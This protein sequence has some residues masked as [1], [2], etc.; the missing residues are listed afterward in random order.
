MSSFTQ[1]QRIMVVLGCKIL[2]INTHNNIFK[3]SK[4]TRT[5]SADTLTHH[6]QAQH[7]SS[8]TR[9]DHKL[10]K[11]LFSLSTSPR[12][13]GYA[14]MGDAAPPTQ[15]IHF[16]SLKFSSITLTIRLH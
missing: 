14:H 1:I 8:F 7:T 5:Q 16:N 11:R 3:I 6:S 2:A 12:L 4:K 15:Y 13:G 10:P 9:V